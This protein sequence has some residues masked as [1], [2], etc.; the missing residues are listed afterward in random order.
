MPLR[1]TCVSWTLKGGQNE[2]Q[3]A[4]PCANASG[5]RAH[6]QCHGRDGSDADEDPERPRQ[7]NEKQRNHEAIPTEGGH[8]NGAPIFGGWPIR[9]KENSMIRKLASGGYRLYSRKKDP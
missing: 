1:L 8:V 4:L 6:D 7:R 5:H 9:W 3:E 2:S